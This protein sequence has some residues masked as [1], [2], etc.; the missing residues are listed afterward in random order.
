[1]AV[2]L[3]RPEMEGNAE[4]E[5]VAEFEREK[6]ADEEDEPVGRLLLVLRK[7]PEFVALV[8]A[9]LFALAE[10]APEQEPLSVEGALPEKEGELLVE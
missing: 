1:M 5:T 4:V 9:L 8:D 7:L 10:E 2:R 3:C 6:V